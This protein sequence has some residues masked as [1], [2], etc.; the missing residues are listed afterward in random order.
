VNIKEKISESV[1]YV[2]N[3]IIR[4]NPRLNIKEK[5][6]DITNVKKG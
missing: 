1:N 2:K 6:N 4:E 5:K 3:Y